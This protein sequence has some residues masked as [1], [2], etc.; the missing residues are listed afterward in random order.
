MNKFKNKYNH[1]FIISDRKFSVMLEAKT[2]LDDLSARTVLVACR[3][4]VQYNARFPSTDMNP[5]IAQKFSFES[6]FLG[7][8]A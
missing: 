3:A 7:G 4:S 6:Y 2:S 1:H 5:K 8:T